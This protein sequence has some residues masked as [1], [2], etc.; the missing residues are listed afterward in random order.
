[1]LYR[2]YS[3]PADA[4]IPNIYGGREKPRG[5]WFSFAI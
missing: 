3:R 2:D 5:G 1:M 4:W